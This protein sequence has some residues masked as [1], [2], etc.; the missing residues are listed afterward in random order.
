ME[1]APGPSTPSEGPLTPALQRQIE[2]WFVSHG[3]PQL[4]E[5]YATEERMD[6]RAAP[7]IAVWIVAGTVFRWGAHPDWLM[8]W[9]VASALGAVLF[10]ALGYVAVRWS[11]GRPAWPRRRKLDV[12]DIVALGVLVAVPAGLSGGS[13]RDG[14]V[15]G[16]DALLGIGVIYAVIG[17]GLL[18]IGLWGIGRLQAELV[19]I[20][21]LLARTLPILLILVLF[22]LFASEI[23]VVAHE[24]HGGELAALLLL[25]VA[26]AAL[27][28][29]TALRSE[30]REG[31]PS[32][33]LR[34]LRQARDTPAAPLLE[35]LNEPLADVPPLTWLQRLNVAILVLIEQL[36]HSL[37]VALL[38]MAFLLVIGLLAMPGSLQEQWVGGPVDILARFQ[39]LG[40]E[41]ALSAELIAVTALLGAVVGLYFTGLAV[42]DAAYRADHFG[43]VIDEVRRLLA[44]RVLYV[45]A[46]SQRQAANGSFARMPE[47]LR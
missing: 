11:R 29:L 37:I 9:S 5:G 15:A 39:L 17:L 19:G 1:A 42:T 16:L 12:V 20:V 6:V 10:I 30:I 31:E 34:A 33:D 13:L 27:L 18:E 32:N 35:G 3:V 36:I 23:W 2:R 22:L 40:E 7:F 28:V 45:S 41:R 4:V 21:G 38:V 26:I 25:L 14:I 47:N 43:R 44:A 8:P 24:L 46:L